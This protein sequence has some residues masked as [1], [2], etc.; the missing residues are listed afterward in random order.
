MACAVLV[1]CAVAGCVSRQEH[2]ELRV[3]FT[4]VEAERNR[5]NDE[6]TKLRSDWEKLKDKDATVAL[7]V[8][9]RASLSELQG[10]CI[11][12][13]QRASQLLDEA[14]SLKIERNSIRSSAQ[15]IQQ[16]RLEAERQLEQCKALFAKALRGPEYGA[17]GDGH[18]VKEKIGRGEYIL[19]EDGSLWE[20]SRLDRIDT[21]L[22]LNTESIV[23]LEN[24]SGL[25]PYKL[26]NTDSEDV[27]EAKYLGT[28]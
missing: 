8:E 7:V 9:L 17:V 21:A 4:T 1:A 5:I 15:S 18:W 28:R 25:L 20:I 3:Q 27:V 14:Q 22:W 6:L 23:V 26:I 11:E 10:K 12:A 13:E 24:T 16:R 19:L 2:N